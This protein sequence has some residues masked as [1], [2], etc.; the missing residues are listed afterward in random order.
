MVSR[1]SGMNWSLSEITEMEWQL[2]DLLGRGVAVIGDEGWEEFEIFQEDAWMAWDD[3]KRKRSIKV[4]K[5]E[6]QRPAQRAEEEGSEEAD[7]FVEIVNSKLGDLI[8][9]NK[10]DRRRYY[11]PPPSPRYG[12]LPIDMKELRTVL[13]VTNIEYDDDED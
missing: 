10:K 6:D 5:P 2:F 4:P 1:E 7:K 9:A 13:R 11:S 3:E 8:I 12:N